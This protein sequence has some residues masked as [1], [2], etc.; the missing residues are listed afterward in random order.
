LKKANLDRTDLEELYMSQKLG[1]GEVGRR[2]GVS[3][4]TVRRRLKDYGIPLRGCSESQKEA[5][6][7]GRRLNPN[8]GKK[9]PLSSRW[10]P[11]LTRRT[12]SGHIQVRELGHPRANKRGLVLEHIL[13]WERV[14]SRSLP[15]NW[16]VHH[17][18]GIGTDNRPQNLLALPT[19]HHRRIISELKRRIRELEIEN[20]QLRSTLDGV[21]SVMVSEN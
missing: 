1:A 10:K 12:S 16:E 17:V 4:N 8:F 11:S 15:E 18:N 6:R 20:G 9:G 21:S 5:L 7:T 2:L 13:I 19:R 14:N 3:K